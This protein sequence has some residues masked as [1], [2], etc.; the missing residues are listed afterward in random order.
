LPVPYHS[1]SAWRLAASAAA[2]SV[3]LWS[4]T[5]LAALPRHRSLWEA[6]AA[7]VGQTLGEWITVQ[8]ARRSS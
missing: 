8:A 3:D 5:L 4:E 7:E 2:E 6:A 1:A